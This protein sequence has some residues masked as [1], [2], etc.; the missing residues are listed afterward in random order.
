MLSPTDVQGCVWAM[1]LID[2]GDRVMVGEG[3]GVSE[4]GTWN[5]CAVL[6]YGYAVPSAGRL[7]LKRA[8]TDM[9]V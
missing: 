9:C 6:G 5:A 4:R 7:A 1:C 8:P 3:Q 2:T